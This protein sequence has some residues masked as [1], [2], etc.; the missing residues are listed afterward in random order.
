M[1]REEGV[2]FEEPQ[3]LKFTHAS[4]FSS[5]LDAGALEN[6]C[7]SFEVE[8]CLVNNVRE[9]VVQSQMDDSAEQIVNADVPSLSS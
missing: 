5:H 4:S 3:L 6:H 7:P 8:R 2:L 9:I 1:N